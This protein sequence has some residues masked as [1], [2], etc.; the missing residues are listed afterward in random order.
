MHDHNYIRAKIALHYT[1]SAKN[2]FPD[3]DRP[4]IRDALADLVECRLL[5]PR[6][7][8]PGKY[9]AAPALYRWIED[10]CATPLPVLP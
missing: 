1:G 6:P 10:A 4:D 3:W 2:M 7:E 9:E 8:W 5:I